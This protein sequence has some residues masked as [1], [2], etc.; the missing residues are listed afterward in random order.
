MN[1]HAIL[2]KT[3]N[4]SMMK[5]GLSWLK[6]HPIIGWIG[7]FGASLWAWLADHANNVESIAVAISALAWAGVS[8]F[9]LISKYKDFRER[10][11]RERQQNE[12]YKE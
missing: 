9:T 6:D 4:S 1:K 2:P 12:P 7:T 8:I 11:R 10:R 5:L 3:R